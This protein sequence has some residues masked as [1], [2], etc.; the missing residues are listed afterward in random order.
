MCG[1]GRETLNVFRGGRI[2]VGVEA[3]IRE[4]LDIEIQVQMGLNMHSHSRCPDEKV[5]R[6]CIPVADA[7]QKAE[8]S[9]LYRVSV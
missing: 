4:I 6:T 1:D 9:S 8:E 5:G 7:G 3:V 2:G